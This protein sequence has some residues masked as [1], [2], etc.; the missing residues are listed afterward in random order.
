VPLLILYRHKKQ[1]K[2]ASISRGVFEK[3]GWLQVVQKK[4]NKLSQALVMTA[5]WNLFLQ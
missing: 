1:E 4:K 5:I 2:N 3:I